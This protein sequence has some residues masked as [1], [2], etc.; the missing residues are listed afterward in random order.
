MDL[1]TA[2]RENT[3]S[4]AVG[5]AA[6]AFDR[7]IDFD[8]SAIGHAGAPDQFVPDR[9]AAFRPEALVQ[10][11]FLWIGAVAAEAFKMTCARR[12]RGIGIPGPHH[13]LPQR[14]LERLILVVESVLPFQK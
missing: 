5:G 12:R 14:T 4:G 7:R 10:R 3:A 11:D 13:G 9:I 1:R 2:E 8:S 6:P